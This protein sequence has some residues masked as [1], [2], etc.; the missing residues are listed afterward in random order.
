MNACLVT[1]GD[2]LKI[3]SQVNTLMIVRNRLPR[4]NFIDSK[5]HTIHF[6]VSLQLKKMLRD[7]EFVFWNKHLTL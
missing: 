1:A 6:C 3:T 7:F 2:V 5:V 4:V